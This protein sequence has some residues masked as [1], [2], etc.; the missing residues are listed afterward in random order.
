[1]PGWGADCPAEDSGPRAARLARRG[2][3]RWPRGS[4]PPLPAQEEAAREASWETLPLYLQ[5]PE[6][7]KDVRTRTRESEPS[8]DGVTHCVALIHIR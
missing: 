4:R 1:M 6:Q 3:D 7:Q 8:C 2:S 5:Q